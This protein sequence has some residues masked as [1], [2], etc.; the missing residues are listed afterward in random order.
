MVVGRSSISKLHAGVLRLAHSHG[1]LW[2]GDRRR[3]HV[4]IIDGPRQIEVHDQVEDSGFAVVA[5][6]IVVVVVVV[7]VPGDHEDVEK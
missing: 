1:L 7:V 3:W 2:V 6:D 4:L 5:D